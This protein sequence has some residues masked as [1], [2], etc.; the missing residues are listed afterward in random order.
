MIT[1]T[2]SKLFIAF[3]FFLGFNNVQAQLDSVHYHDLSMES[4]WGST[5]VN[6]DFGCFVRITP[7]TYPATLRGI[8]GYFRNAAAGSTFKWKVYVDQTGAGN[9][10]GGI[11]YFS[12][13]P[14]AN[15]AAGTTNQQY[16][17]YIDLTSSNIVIPQG[18]VYVGAVQTT[19]FAGFGMDSS[20]S[21]A[22]TR[23]W[24]WMTVFNQNYWNTMQSQAANLELGFTAF[25][26]ALTTGV[27]GAYPEEMINV[28]PNPANNVLHVQLP[29]TDNA[30][31]IK[32]TDLAGRTV[33][34]QKVIELQT[35]VNLEN[36]VAGVYVVNIVTDK[37]VIT[38]KIVK[39]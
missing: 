39:Q 7:T 27:N 19:G 31:V 4:Q 22:P 8:R 5:T 11:F 12:P 26:T 28:F 3:L 24:Q 36:F 18:D 38:R 25:F 34:E 20:S 35:N 29:S 9:G 2:T 13:S 15:P 14:V 30:P 17:S 37:Q 33:A 10:G 6:D 1:K 23:Q 32:I 16:A 21:T